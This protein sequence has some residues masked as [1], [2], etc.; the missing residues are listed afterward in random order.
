MPVPRISNGGLSFQHNN[1]RRRVV[2]RY[3]NNTTSVRRQTIDSEGL[4]EAREKMTTPGIGLFDEDSRSFFPI[5]PDIS[6]IASDADQPS[7]QPERM[8]G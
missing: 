4:M 3:T 2:R 1:A 7:P 8:E 6:S 5:L